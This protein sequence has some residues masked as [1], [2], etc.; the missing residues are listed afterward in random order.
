M[1]VR[2]KSK[3]HFSPVVWIPVIQLG[4]SLLLSAAGYW[5]SIQ[6]AVSV[7]LG[8]LIC[9]VGNAV[10]IW[11]FFRHGNSQSARDLLKDAYQGAFSKLLLTALLFAIVLNVFEEL[12]ILLLFVGFIAAQAVNWIAPLVMKRPILNKT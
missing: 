9:L 4:V 12:K 3:H 11:R 1:T 10:F 7:L 8:G 6:H 2:R 5:F